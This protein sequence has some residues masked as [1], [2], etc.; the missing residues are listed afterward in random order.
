VSIYTPIAERIRYERLQEQFAQIEEQIVDDP[1]EIPTPAPPPPIPTP[2]T[3][4]PPEP[5]PT[6]EPTPPQLHPKSIMYLEWNEDYC[7]EIWIPDS[8]DDKY[9]EIKFPVVQTDHW[10]SQNPYLH[11]D[12]NRDKS[13][14]GNPFASSSSDNPI[15]VFGHHLPNV[16]AG[17]EKYKDSDYL[18]SHRSIQLTTLYEEQQYQ[19]IAVYYFTQE[20]VRNEL[21]DGQRVTGYVNR[22]LNE[23]EER[24]YTDI[25][26]TGDPLTFLKFLETYTCVYYLDADIEATEDSQF[27]SLQCCTYEDKEGR[28]IKKGRL[29]IMAMK[30]EQENAAG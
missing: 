25:Y 15:V 29:V 8:A 6:P 16:F 21:I 12:F 23:D 18:E 2:E 1:P 24:N 30:V 10:D 4:N 19:V 13:S 17:L 22:D 27:L 14:D 9:P 28:S 7:F 5:T 11:L 20:Y 3:T 26:G